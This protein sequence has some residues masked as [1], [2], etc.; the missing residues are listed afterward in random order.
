MTVAWVIGGGGLI[1]TAL[2]IA[3]AETGALVF[4]PVGSLSWTE[5]STARAQLAASFR[6][7]EQAASA[8]E[9]WEIYWA[10][11]RGTMHSR[12]VDLEPE[13][14]L[15]SALCSAVADS[16][17][18]RHR[19]GGVAFASSAGAVYG[20]SNQPILTE[21]SDVAP[22]NAYARAKLLQEGVLSLAL[23][24][25]P[26]CA[27]LLARISTVYGSAQASGKAQGLLSH[28]AGCIVRNQPVHVYVP[29]D[30]I[31][32]YIAVADAAREMM[33]QLRE[34]TPGQPAAVRL[35]ASERPT[36]I[37]EIVGLFKRLSWRPPRLVTC[38]APAAAAYKRRIQF[39][40]RYPACV[41]VRSRTSLAV[42]IAGLLADACARLALGG[43]SVQKRSADHPR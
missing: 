27:V 39:R 16:H 32:D 35:I 18:L 3:L 15:L 42:G 2:R 24:D 29:L 30:T 19:P 25:L 33:L 23:T 31:R 21:C 8:A 20:G 22:A 11:G 38:V 43:R 13:T 37:S 5:I 10:A 14:A 9:R 17:V 41:E 34:L 36:T 40:S 26:A 12:D 1:G 6:E 28:I 7:F 4:V